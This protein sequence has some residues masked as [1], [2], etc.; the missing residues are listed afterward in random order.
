MIYIKINFTI[1]IGLYKYCILEIQFMKLEK[2][3]RKK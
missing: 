2:K 3:L 1:K